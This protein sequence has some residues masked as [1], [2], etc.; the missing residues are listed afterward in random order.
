MGEIR[1][2]RCFRKPFL[3]YSAEKY[4]ENERYISFPDVDGPF[5]RDWNEINVRLKHETENET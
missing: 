4:N 5:D 3:K 1:E 2:V